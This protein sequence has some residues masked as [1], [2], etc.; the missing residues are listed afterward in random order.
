MLP[1]F[2]KS[3]DWE[4]GED[5]YRG[6]GGPL[7]V[8]KSTFEDPLCEAFLA[9]GRDAQYPFTDDY[10]GAEQEGFARMQATLRNGWRWSAAAAYLHPALKRPNLR[11][12]VLVVT[13]FR[14]SVLRI[15]KGP[16]VN[17]SGPNQV[18]VVDAGLR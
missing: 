8:R 5:A 15:G 11:I 13:D 14:D 6:V 18:F 9:A 10:N 1:Y 7:T 12:E 2:R 17:G 4:G 3:E 16:F